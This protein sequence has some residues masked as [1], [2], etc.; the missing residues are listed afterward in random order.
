MGTSVVLFATYLYNSQD[1]AA[2][3]PPIQIHSYEKTTVDTHS[4]REKDTPMKLPTTPLKNEG[5][6]TSRP[7]SPVLHHTR[8]GS[9][10]GYFGK[11][12]DE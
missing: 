5:L 8:T 7:G 12:R 2:R 3:P 1:R 9:S 10:R 11:H 4:A 6:S